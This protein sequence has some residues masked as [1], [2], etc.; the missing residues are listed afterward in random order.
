M[1]GLLCVCVCLFETYRVVLYGAFICGMFFCV[2]F[3]L[4]CLC[5]VWGVLRDVVQFVF[6]VCFCVCLR[7]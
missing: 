6:C 7:L 1:F 5:V 2:L 3:M 4:V